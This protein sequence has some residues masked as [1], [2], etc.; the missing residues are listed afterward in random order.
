MI[1]VPVDWPYRLPYGIICAPEHSPQ[2]D[3]FINLIDSVNDSSTVDPLV[4]V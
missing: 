3:A 2:V 4:P 1:T